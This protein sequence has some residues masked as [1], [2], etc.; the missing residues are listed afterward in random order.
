MTTFEELFYS[1]CSI[2]QIVLYNIFAII[3]ICVN[4]ALL[5]T[6]KYDF[7]EVLLDSITL[8]SKINQNIQTNYKKIYDENK[9]FQIVMDHV[10]YIMKCFN[11]FLNNQ[12]IEPFVNEW[13]NVSVINKAIYDDFQ[14]IESYEYIND[15][16]EIIVDY[17]DSNNHEPKWKISFINWYNTVNNILKN[18]ALVLNGSITMKYENCYIHRECNENK[19]LNEISFEPSNISFI[20]VELHHPKLKNPLIIDIEKGYYIINNELLSFTFIKRYLE[21]HENMQNFDEYYTVKVMTNNI[22]EF[23]IKS[24]EYVVLK[25]D[26]YEILK[27]T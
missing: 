20:S 14:L 8:Y 9:T 18:D 16:E 12:R 23:E 6:Q 5:I 26:S 10:F 22:E 15:N 21:Y 2:I 4:N 7:N 17:P 1:T 19:I 25:K 11:A 13:I 24:D 3:N 27:D